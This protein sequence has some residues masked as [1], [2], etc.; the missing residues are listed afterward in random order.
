MIR[1]YVDKSGVIRGSRSNR[2]VSGVLSI[3]VRDR[4]RPPLMID[5]KAFAESDITEVRIS[6]PHLVMINACAFDHC[7]KLRYVEL[8][9]TITRI[10]GYAFSGCT[11]LTSIRI[12]A[13]IDV[14]TECCFSDTGLI[15]AEIPYGV[16]SIEEGAFAWCRML[17]SVRL[18]SSLS[19]IGNYAFGRCTALESIEI[20]E[21]VK[22]IG[23][24]AFL[25]CLNLREVSLPASLEEIGDAAFSYCS[26][27][28]SI[29]Y[30]GGDLPDE[31][32]QA[33][34]KCPNINDTQLFQRIRVYESGK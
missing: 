3:P 19:V 23:D 31:W 8:P 15:E 22:K 27:L 6:D 7:P 11:S 18:P 21:G 20:P 12:P 2:K 16:L 30:N 25:Q 28:E 26:R 33:F 34:R 9:N 10:M 17:R 4:E 14:I 24:G 5:I 29:R 32:L 1:Y 13:H